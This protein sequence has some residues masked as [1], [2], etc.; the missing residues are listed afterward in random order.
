MKM[1]NITLT[2]TAMLAVCYGIAQAQTFVPPAPLLWLGFDGNLTDKGGSIN[3][4]VVSFVGSGCSFISD[5]ANGTACLL[6]T[7]RCV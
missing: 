2:L 1:K 7:S 4:H 3:G 5:V 6:Y